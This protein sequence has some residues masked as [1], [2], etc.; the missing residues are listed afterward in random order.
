VRQAAVTLL[1]LQEA[2]NIAILDERMVLCQILL[3]DIVLDFVTNTIVSIRPKPEYE[4]LF[5]MVTSLDAI[6]DGSYGHHFG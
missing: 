3:K 6:G 5:Q 4:V 2:W 1:R